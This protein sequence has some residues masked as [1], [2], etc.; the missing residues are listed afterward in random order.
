MPDDIERWWDGHNQRDQRRQAQCATKRAFL[1]EEEARAHATADRAQFGD[2][3]DPY[4]CDLCGD[5]HLT[6]RSPPAH[7]R[8]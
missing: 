2:R 7:R 5:W 4:L 6:R 8:D 1:S 3:F